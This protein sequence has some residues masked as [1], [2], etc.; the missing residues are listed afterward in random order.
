MTDHHAE[1]IHRWQEL[2]SAAA[3]IVPIKLPL[4]PMPAEILAIKDDLEVL[5]GVVD[6]LV[7]AYGLYVQA[8]SGYTIDPKLMRGQ[9][10]GALDGNLLYEIEC[11]AAKIS[12]DLH[13][14]VA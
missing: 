4:E 2:C 12:D 7:E 3:G 11:A 1:I 9:L 14:A 10:L 6:R 8:S 5:A 13:D